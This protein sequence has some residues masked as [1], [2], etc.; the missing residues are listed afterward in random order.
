MQGLLSAFL[1]MSDNNA[2]LFASFMLLCIRILP[3]VYTDI[4]M[5]ISSLHE[6]Q[7][8]SE[9]AIHDTLQ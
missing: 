3:E 9:C 5:H 2:R 7:S 6:H 4:N 8:D 1:I